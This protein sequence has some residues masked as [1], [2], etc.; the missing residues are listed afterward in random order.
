M[1]TKRIIGFLI[2]DLLL[3]ITVSNNIS[4][5]GRVNFHNLKL[6][7]MKRAMTIN[8]LTVQ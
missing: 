1:K 7:K 8:C 4:D 6:K 2:T 5:L 3:V